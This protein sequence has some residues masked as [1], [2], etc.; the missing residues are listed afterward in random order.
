MT[1]LD[2]QRC[3]AAVAKASISSRLSG[4]GAVWIGSA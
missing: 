1:S 2:S 3:E 4:Q